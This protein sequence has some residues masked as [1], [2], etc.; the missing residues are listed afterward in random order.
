MMGP[1]ENDNKEN[2]IK[3]DYKKYFCYFHHL[4][5]LIEYFRHFFLFLAAWQI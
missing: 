5:E 4:F 1:E 2:N 3:M